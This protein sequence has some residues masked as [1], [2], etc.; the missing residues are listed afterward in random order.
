MNQHKIAAEVYVKKT[1]AANNFM[2]AGIAGDFTIQSMEG[3]VNDVVN[4]KYDG[5]AN[6]FYM[7]IGVEM[8]F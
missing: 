2:F 6:K 5:K 7:P 4:L 8:F 1:F 3:L